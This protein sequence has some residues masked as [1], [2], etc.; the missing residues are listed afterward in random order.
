MSIFSSLFGGYNRPGPGVRPDE[1]RKKGV[2]RLLEVLGRD[3]WS[4]FKAGFLAFLS[5]LPFVACMVLAIDTHALIFVLVGCT[6]SG[7]IAAPQ[8]C[9]MADT[10]LRS[11]RDEPGYWW[12]T[13]CRAWKRN[14]AATLLPGALC[15]LVFGMQIFTFWHM[16][17]IGTS[18]VSW[19]ALIAGLILSIGLQ[20]YMIPQ[21][22]LL[23]LP[24]FGILKNAVLLLLGY[25][26]RSV[27]AI[28]VQVLYWGVLM[29]FF[30]V[31][32]LLFPFTNFWLPMTLS[33]LIIYDPMEKSFNIEKTIKEMREAQMQSDEE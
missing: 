27:G 9:G 10:V 17:S 22:A 23:D 28:A 6:I 15:G 25:L 7:M 2:A 30:P 14:A 26:P 18:L 24:L 4:F 29:L 13:Y 16:D 5:F 8:V 31:S 33:L 12:N 19:V 20:T 1:P 32:L 21:L 11:L 3:L